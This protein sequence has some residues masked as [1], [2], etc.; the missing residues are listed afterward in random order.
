MAQSPEKKLR[1]NTGS[2]LDCGERQV[3]LPPPLPPVGDDFD[4]QVRD[5]DGFNRFILEEL[6]ARFPE[7]DR[8]TPADMEVVI[9][10]ALSTVLDRLSDMLDRVS[11]EAVLKTARRPDSVRRLLAMIGY[12]AVRLA[13]KEAQIDPTVERRDQE[14]ALEKYWRGSRQAMEQAKRAG[15]RRIHTQRRM[16]TLSDYAERLEDHPLVLRASSWEKWGGAWSVIC[17]ATIL[18]EGR[19]LDD[20]A[21]LSPEARR[22]VD[23]FNFANGLNPVQ[24]SARPTFR[25]VLTPLIERF[26]LVG[27]EVVLSD[28]IRVG[29]SMDLIISV[30]PRFYRFEVK[31]AVSVALGQG[32]NGFFAPGRLT[33]GE[34][35]HLSDVIQQLMKTA[36]VANL[37]F[38]EFKRV[39]PDWPDA[40]T[41]G[42]IE[43]SGQE[44]AVCSNDPHHPEQGGFR[45]VVQGGKVG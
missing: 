32:P 35:L 10:D 21:L 37:L 13:P 12:D 31:D 41:A 20:E 6:A 45:V 29:I 19:H 4:W 27:Q 5:Y 17:L 3:A 38:N 11:A 36:G 15:P 44:F 22:Q 1:F 16:V 18:P 26:R 43:L 30:D 34:D 42:T 33:F 8:W 2:S 25:T 24:W 7:R 40:G 14:A 39:G 28:G 23:G 9:I